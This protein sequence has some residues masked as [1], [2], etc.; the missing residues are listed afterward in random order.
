MGEVIEP[1]WIIIFF[2]S[3]A[4]TSTEYIICTFP[5]AIIK[6]IIEHRSRKKVLD[7]GVCVSMYRGRGWIDWWDVCKITLH[8]K[9]FICPLHSQSMLLDNDASYVTSDLQNLLPLSYLT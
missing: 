8:I 4:S 2:L 9:T 1:T 6:Y 7:Y 3:V 5:Y